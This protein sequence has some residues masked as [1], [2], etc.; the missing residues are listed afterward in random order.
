MRD[1]GDAALPLKADMLSV[2]IDVCLVPGADIRY[3][4]LATA[5]WAHLVQ[6]LDAGYRGLIDFIPVFTRP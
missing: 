6:L 2:A 5:F 4:G 1:I 3:T